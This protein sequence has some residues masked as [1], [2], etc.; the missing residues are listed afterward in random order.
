M[1]YT[2]YERKV[3]NMINQI[4]QAIECVETLQ[5]N[6]DFK[7]KYKEHLMEKIKRSEDD[8]KNGRF[9]T[10]EQ[11]SEFVEELKRGNIVSANNY[12]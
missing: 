7:A 1:Y 6:K 5:N 12:I 8:F 2:I 9:L 3:I 10:F 4:S 11:F